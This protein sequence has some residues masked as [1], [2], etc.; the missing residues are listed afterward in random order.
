MDGHLM[1]KRLSN[2]SHLSEERWKQLL[3]YFGEN[4]LSLEE[5]CSLL[6]EITLHKDIN[7]E[8]NSKD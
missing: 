5:R 6:N 7:R 1:N 8:Q 4:S 3:Q 2:L